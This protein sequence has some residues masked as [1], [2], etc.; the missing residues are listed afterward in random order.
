MLGYQA[1]PEGPGNPD[2]KKLS[3][4]G[5]SV[6]LVALL[7]FIDIMLWTFSRGGSLSIVAALAAVQAKAPAIDVD[8]NGLRFLMLL[9]VGAIALGMSRFFDVEFTSDRRSTLPLVLAI[10]VG[11][12]V[13]DGL[14][15]ETIITKYM[16]AEGYGRCPSQDRAVGTGKGRV[17]FENYELSASGC[18]A[19]R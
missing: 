2:A 6:T 16:A 17:W 13:L 15:G 19:A 7:L 4:L 3:N 10:F 1:G 14:C 8:R 9:M 12:F 18:R 5:L 11:G